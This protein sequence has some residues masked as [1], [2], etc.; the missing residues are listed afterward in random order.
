MSREKIT[1][2]SNEIKGL[3]LAGGK[4]TR[5]LPLTADT[6]K[7]LLPVGDKPLVLY[8]IENLLKAGVKDIL[9]LIDDRH[10]SQYMQLLNDGSHLGVRSLA[11]IWQPQEGKGLP[12]AILQAEPFIKSERLVVVCG[13][14]IIEEG[15]K[16]P[17]SD[18][19]EQ[20]NGARLC[21]TKLEDTAGYSPLVT[22]LDIVTRILPKDKN[23]HESGLIDLG[24]YMYNPDVFEKIKDLK[25]SDRG[26]T[27]I[28]ELNNK[29]SSV[30]RLHFSTISGWWSDVGSNMETYILANKHYG[31]QTL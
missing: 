11:Y 27:E 20:R 4:G 31:K 3:V 29:Y 28:W 9:L 5:L 18:F 6:S 16:K 30:N 26:E 2:T 21:A 8:A 7:Q 17:I 24:I 19:I 13:D 23:V 15:I 25:P 1:L 14:V 10:A 22:N 12:S